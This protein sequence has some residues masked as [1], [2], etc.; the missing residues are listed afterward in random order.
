MTQD[1]SRD[2]KPMLIEPGARIL[3]HSA[4]SV[5]HQ[6]WASTARFPVHSIGGLRVGT[7]AY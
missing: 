4:R 6:G 7:L 1:Y 2:K 3:S 5:G